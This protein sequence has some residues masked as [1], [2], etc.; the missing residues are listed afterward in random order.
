MMRQMTGRRWLHRLQAHIA[1]AVL[2]PKRTTRAVVL[3]ILVY[4]ALG[5]PILIGLK[6]AQ[7][8]FMDAA[9][10]YVWGQR[11]LGGYGKHPPLTGWI[12]AVWYSVFPAEDWASYTLSHV[13][14]GISLVCIYFIGRR[15]LD[16][17]RSVLLVFAMMLYPLFH[18]GSNRFNN[19]QVLIAVIPLLVLTFLIAFERRTAFWGCLLGVS[20]AAA[21]LTMY[22]GL[23]A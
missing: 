6:A 3:C 8:L 13:M 14:V 7:D 15:V 11:F 18:Y 1:A 5:I 12:A 20:A 23:I 16:N 17:R 22:S 10:A 21:S 19:Y 9:E 2:G 4:A